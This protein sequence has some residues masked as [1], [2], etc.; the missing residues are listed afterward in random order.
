MME[1][2]ANENPPSDYP[3][4]QPQFQTQQHHQQ[5]QQQPPAFTQQA[6]YYGQ[7]EN[8]E[9]AG[10]IQPSYVGEHGQHVETQ[11]SDG[12]PSVY[13]LTIITSNIPPCYSNTPADAP[14][15]SYRDSM[16]GKVTAAKQSSGGNVDFCKKIMMIINGSIGCAIT[17]AFVLVIPITMIVMGAIHRIKNDCPAERMIPIYL[18]VG[19]S[20]GIIK[21]LSSIRQRCKNKDDED[22]DEKNAN[23]NL[24]DKTINL[25]LFAW[26]IAGNV[27]IYRIHGEWSK[28]PTQAN[29]C[30]PSLYWFAFWLTTA[31][32]I[33]VGSMFCCICL[34]T[35]LVACG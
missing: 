32:Y 31:M 19:G 21:I 33:L 34:A 9:H 25:F 14:P 27:L 11:M 20:F 10:Y 1:K 2:T 8:K 15:P 24:F 7:P 16:Y 6:V 12:P 3:V 17:L 4:S 26:F 28:D 22:R 18:I 23:T 35:M 5:Q 29:Y 30:E 13:E